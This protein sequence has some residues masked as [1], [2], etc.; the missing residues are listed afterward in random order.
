MAL[1]N[2]GL[3]N[4]AAVVLDARPYEN[5]AINVMAR[6]QAKEEALDNYYRDL[7]KTINPA[8]VR[9][10]DMQGFMQKTDEL[11]RFWQQNKDAIKNPRL[12][13][14]KAQTEYQSR[15]QDALG[16]VNESK[17]E[18]LKV[19]PLIDIMADPDKR[20]RIPNMVLDKFGLHLL[21][22]TDPNRQSFDFS[23]IDFEPK[24]LDQSKYF[25]SFS[26]IK[27]SDLAPDILTDPKTL[28]RTV[29]TKSAYDDGAK[30][31]IAVRAA[32]IYNSD[33]S[34]HEFIQ[35]LGGNEDQ[36]NEYNKLF[37]QEFGRDIKGNEELAAA[38]TLK[39]L[40]PSIERQDVQTDRVAEMD[41]RYAQEKQLAAIRQA[42]AKELIN[43]RHNLSDGDDEVQDVWID[44]YLDKSKQE[45]IDS[46]D[47]FEYT[48]EGKKEYGYPVQLDPTLKKAVGFDDKNPGKLLVTKDGKY[49]TV[50]YKTDSNYQPI[51]RNGYQVVDSDKTATISKDQL[52]LALGVKVTSAKQRDK[53]MMNNQKPSRKKQKIDW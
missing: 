24:P 17:Q 43:L 15:F 45:A 34:F 20:S 16:Y 22:L 32:G 25:S 36:Y 51:V 48:K 35:K 19:K 14:G 12:D 5:F 49:I 4:G 44:S 52:K 31:A 39:G 27:R 40:Q 2:S 11:Q 50:F 42:N 38:Y 29:S 18:E 3:Y 53:E 46:N 6:K 21:P 8:G 1:N 30:Q 26:D 23:K 10:Q 9:T 47:P 28:T 33:P 13:Q 37:R 41:K 7:N